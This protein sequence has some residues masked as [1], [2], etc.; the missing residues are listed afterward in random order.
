MN[1][2][3][4]YFLKRSIVQRRGRFLLAATAVTLTATAVTALLT[5]SA[6]VRERIG[7]QVQQYGAN[8]LV[9]DS[10]G[11]TISDDRVRAVA[12]LARDARSIAVEVYG[13]LS[14]GSTVVEVIGR[15]LEHMTGYRIEGRLP[16]A[17]GDVMAGTLLRERLSVKLGDR[18]TPR[19]H[20]P[21]TVTAFYERGTD[22]DA[23]LIMPLSLAREL[24]GLNGVS[25]VL[26]SVDT[27]ALD[28][29]ERTLSAADLRLIPRKVLQVAVAEKSLLARVQLLMALVTA[30]VAAASVIALG[31]TMGASVVERREEIGLMAS[32]GAVPHQIRAFF[33]A[34][35][36]A[37]GALGSL[38][39]YA[40][41]TIAAEAVAFTAFGGQVPASL[42]A[43]PIAIMLGTLIATVA[44]LF[45]VR[46]A[47]NIAP[48]TILRGE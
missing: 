3:F 39:G 9:T 7:R 24:L 37:A 20:G 12:E 46:D 45:P 13:S 14:V 6:G 25:A 2:W 19:G 28:D 38:I 35:A 31:S 41:G 4:L 15:D 42:P 43:L 44:S 40:F 22:E 32:L 47:L 18:V 33:L 26:L 48:A 21:L 23:A 27:A 30:V 29:L 5:V 10:A 1:A 34:E 16:A 17:V 36:V 8:L 11:G